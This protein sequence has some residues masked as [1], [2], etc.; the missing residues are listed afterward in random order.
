VKISLSGLLTALAVLGIGALLA[1]QTPELIR[2]LKS[3]AM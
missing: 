3:E 1:Q 2:Y